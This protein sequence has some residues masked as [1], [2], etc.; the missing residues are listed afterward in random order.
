MLLDATHN[1]LP[2]DAPVLQAIQILDQ[3]QAKIALVVDAGGKLVGSVVDGDVRR[4]LLRGHGLQ[5]PVREIM[6]LQPYVLP[7]HSPRQKILEAM[8]VLEIKQVPLITPDG[9]VAGIAV[10]DVL[11]GLQHRER[12]NHVVVMAGGKG[13]RLLPITQ[14]MP[15]PMVPVGG[16]PILEWIL[17]R[18]AHYGFREF[19]FAINYLGHMIE[20]Y[21]GDGSAFGC[22]IRYVR[23]KEFLGTA[24][25]LSLLPPGDTHPLV[26]TNGDILSGIDFGSLVDFHADGGYMA[27]VCAR[28]H[29]VEVPYGVI[30]VR[31]G[32]LQGIVEKPVYDN[33][34]SAGM[35]VLSP[36]VLPRIPQARVLDMPDLLL[37]LVKDRHRIGVFVL[38]DEWV[39]V[40]RHDDLE[41]AKRTFSAQGG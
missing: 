10:H 1:M 38:E 32:C 27:T 22:R 26:V 4:G 14:D 16:K 21:F 7:V 20:D 2:E 23:E 24:G 29:R 6:H 30:E 3:A 34:I 31:D 41:R 13:K 5:A 28:A 19:T 8:Q 11:L 37:S 40:G 35:Y 36:Q 18:L 33:L 25:A 17:L 15:K 9:S 12:P 39:D